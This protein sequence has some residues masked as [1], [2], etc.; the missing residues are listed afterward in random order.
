M[1]TAAGSVMNRQPSL[2][3]VF[4]DVTQCSLAGSYQCFGET[5]CL[6][7]QGRIASTL[8]KMWCSLMGGHQCF[9][10]NY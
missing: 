5:Y 1:V 10:G 3:V 9:T 8:K 2:N 7:L 4:W 6:H